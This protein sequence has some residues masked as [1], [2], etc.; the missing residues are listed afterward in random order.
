[1]NDKF[2]CEFCNREFAKELSLINHSCEKK[3]RWFQRDEPHA[4]LAFMAWNRFYELNNFGKNKEYYKSYR[5]FIDSRYYIAFAKFGKHMRDLNALEPHKFIDYVIKNNLPLDKWTHDFVYEQYI[6]ELIRK[7]SAEDALERNILLMSE[8]AVQHNLQWSDFFRM[9][10][11][12]QAVLWIK[13]G[14]ISP[15]VLYNANSAVD[16]FERCTPEQ[17][18]IIKNIAP[19]GPWKIRFNKN[20]DSCQFLRKTLTESGM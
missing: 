13:S 5:N 3:R 6:R 19:P 2:V 8:W 12:N 4:R 11:T 7:E 16:F 1:M 17:L 15:W 14:R 20:A 18:S 9:V 10:N